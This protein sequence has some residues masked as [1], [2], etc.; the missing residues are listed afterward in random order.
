M[1]WPLFKEYNN[2]SAT[3][4]DEALKGNIS[5]NQ[6]TDIYFS[7][8]NLDALQEGIR[9]QVYI[10]SGNRHVIDKQS[11]TDLKIVMR[12]T[13][14][15]HG[16]NMPYDILNQVKELNYKV[17][18]YCVDKILSEI[19]MYLRYRADIENN[20]E[21]LARSLNTSSAG[22]KTLQLRDF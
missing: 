5:G 19:G 1:S 15:E 21:P 20:P 13:Y 18:E 6:L 9:Y 2:K 14:Y 22:S 10:R 3:F 7:Q 17:I 4:Q 11:E 8:Q 12:S 16:K